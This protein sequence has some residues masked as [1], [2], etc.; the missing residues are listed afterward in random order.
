M[1][2]QNLYCITH[3]TMV[4]AYSNHAGTG[5]LYLLEPDEIDWC[6]GPFTCCPPPP[7]PD[8]VYFD[9]LFEQED[10]ILSFLDWVNQMEG[11]SNVEG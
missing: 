1:S 4:A 6:E 11:G 7:D 5:H 8:E 3:E 10:S 2:Q 9:Q